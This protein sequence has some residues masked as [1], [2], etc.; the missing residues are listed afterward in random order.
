M[1]ARYSPNRYQVI[2]IT[3]V[4]FSISFVLIVSRI[5]LKYLKFV[6]FATFPTPFFSQLVALRSRILPERK[7]TGLAE[8]KTYGKKEDN[9]SSQPFMNGEILE[10]ANDP[11][12]ERTRQDHQEDKVESLA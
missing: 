1:T 11:K 3:F 4:T 12:Q 6:F 8:L 7:M 10:A 5:C 9:G 2:W